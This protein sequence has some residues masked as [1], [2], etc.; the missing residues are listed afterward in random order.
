METQP[1]VTTTTAHDSATGRS[2]QKASYNWL[3]DRRVLVVASVAI[4]LAAVGF[5]GVVAVERLLPLLFVLPCALMMLMCMRH[6]GG[7]NRAPDGAG[8]NTDP[9]V[10]NR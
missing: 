6:T 7:N 5:S 4:T 9:S 1:A 8:G 3:S 2:D 10:D